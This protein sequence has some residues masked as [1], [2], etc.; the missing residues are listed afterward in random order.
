MKQMTITEALRELSLYDEKITKAFLGKQFVFIVKK[1]NSEKTKK[2][3]KQKAKADY[4]SL[5]KIIANRDEI[6][7]AVIKS[8]ATTTLEVNGKTMTVA[9]AI[10]KKH[11]IEYKQ[12][13][14]QRLASE[15][16]QVTDR[17][18]DMDERLDDEID[19]MLKKIAGSDATDVSDKRKVLEDAYRQT[20]ACEAFDPCNIEKEIERLKEEIDG[21]LK[22]VDVALALSNAVTTIEV[23]L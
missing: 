8:N 13:L 3:L 23:E 19:E 22:D 16:T 5:T 4:E 6:K 14:L 1:A 10:D 20:H 21:F 17:V 9:E 7:S 11:S 12:K 18:K 2:E 15:F